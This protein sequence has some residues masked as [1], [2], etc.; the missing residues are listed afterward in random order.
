MRT[1]TANHPDKQNAGTHPQVRPALDPSAQ[2]SVA[3]RCE[4]PNADGVA[5]ATALDVELLPASEPREIVSFSGGDSFGLIT[6]FAADLERDGHRPFL[7]WKR[8]T[9]G[10]ICGLA[11][12]E[13]VA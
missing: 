7:I 8:D 11:V 12:V 10:V 9:R 2:T 6:R 4:N 5:F 1:T 3:L 13:R